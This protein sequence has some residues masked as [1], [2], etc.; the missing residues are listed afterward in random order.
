[1]RSLDAMPSKMDL[2]SDPKATLRVSLNL[3]RLKVLPPKKSCQMERSLLEQQLAQIS[4]EALL[5]QQLAQISD[6][7]LA[8]NRERVNIT[9]GRPARAQRRQMLL[10]RESM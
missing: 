6:E 2:K 5:E 7:E 9:A 1:M 8:K 10:R 3:H 4:D